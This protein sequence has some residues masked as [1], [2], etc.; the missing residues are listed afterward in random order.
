VRGSLALRWASILA[1]DKGEGWL[2]GLSF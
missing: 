1:T 2:G